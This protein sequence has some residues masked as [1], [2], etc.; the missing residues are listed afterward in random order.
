MPNGN[1]SA[2]LP[3]SRDYH[4]VIVKLT[5][6]KDLDVAKIKE[7]MLL[8]QEFVQA[9]A[10][11]RYSEAMA[12]AQQEMSVISRDASNPQTHSRYATLA[13]LDRAIRPLYTKYGL[14]VSFDEEPSTKDDVAH[15]VADVNCGAYTKRFH[16]HMPWTTL[17][18]QGKA[19]T[20]STHAKM[21]A[22]T[23][24]RRGLLKM[25][26]NLSEGDDDG[27]ARP[28]NLTP[29]HMPE[30]RQSERVLFEMSHCKD[31]VSLENYMAFWNGTWTDETS[32]STER[33]TVKRT[34]DAMLEGFK[35]AAAK[36]V[37]SVDNVAG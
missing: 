22:V 9:E 24:A 14:S 1:A 8:Q 13:S 15:V 12:Q 29:S 23:Y 25:I 19:V 10:K 18:P 31:A 11:A 21:G 16:L 27:N 37:A 34:R 32:T 35:A 30:I 5:T 2:G 36:E 20:T 33:A 6:V 4:D 7:F 26:F 17:G 28:R 3:V